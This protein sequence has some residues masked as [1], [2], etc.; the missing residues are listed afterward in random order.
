MGP[1]RYIL[2]YHTIYSILFYSLLFQEIIR[3]TNL[4]MVGIKEN[5]A[6]IT[7]SGINTIKKAKL[8]HSIKHS[9]VTEPKSF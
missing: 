8:S 1:Y 6:F 9:K 3:D 5:V 7:H 2:I 4:K